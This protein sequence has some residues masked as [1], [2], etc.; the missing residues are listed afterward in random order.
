MEI[1][2]ANPAA[3]KSLGRQK[4]Q[5]I[6]IEFP[7]CF[8]NP[9]TAQ[10]LHVLALK[11]GRASGHLLELK[12]RGGKTAYLLCTA[13]ALKEE[14]SHVMVT[15]RDITDRRVQTPASSG[16]RDRFQIAF[17]FTSI[18]IAMVDLN[19]N[20]LEANQSLAEL[21][22]HSREELENMNLLDVWTPDERVQALAELKEAASGGPSRIVFE[23]QY[24]N[25][26]GEILI[27]EVT[28]GLARNR[29]GTPM[30][31]IVSFRDITESKRLQA[32]LEEQAC[33][34]LLTGTMNRN[35][36]E[37]RAA[38][39]LIRIDRYGNKL[40]LVM[41]DLDNFKTINDVY[42]HNSGDSVLRGFCDLARNCLRSTDL[43]G[44]WGGEEF[45]VLLPETGLKGAHLICERLRC[46][47]EGF[48]FGE[49]I[50]VT[51]SM[52]IAAYREGEELASLLGRADSCMYRAKQNGKNRVV[53][54]AED[55]KREAA[56]PHRNPE[57]L[58]LHWRTCY[59]SGQPLI[60][61]EHEELFRLTNLILTA[62]AELEG[63][64]RML[65]LVRELT[66]HAH[67][68]FRHE[69]KLLQ[70]AGYPE[71]AAHEAIHRQLES[72]AI[73]LTCEFERGGGSPADMLGFLLHD[74]VAKHML[75]EDQKFFP[76]LQ[77]KRA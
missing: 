43:L 10:R 62:M 29:A 20:I 28:R 22:G 37:E 27:A 75:M 30:Y 68:H 71:A 34:D 24:L 70:L 3:A 31:F 36:I 50:K 32:L 42:G 64:F 74:V 7:S 2:E 33:T 77:G 39:E 76:W 19:G 57:L 63:E 69:E 18:G 49:G 35:G 65:P 38:F 47:L 45:V 5:L 72:R 15:A 16:G 55:S 21:F 14:N 44:R 23:R 59:R 8:Q 12:S 53:M 11:D 1:L 46:T 17:E 58:G 13:E 48:R 67:A 54:D 56:S 26:Q 66:A 4:N 40:S 25:R 51:A 9:E 52:G 61:A 60:D 73:E 41:I 6:G